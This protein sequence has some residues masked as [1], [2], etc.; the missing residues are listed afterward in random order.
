VAARRDRSATTASANPIPARLCS[1]IGTSIVMVEIAWE[2]ARP[3]CAP[4]VRVAGR[5]SVW[6]ILARA[7]HVPR[8]TTVIPR[9]WPRRQRVR[10]GRVWGSRVRAARCALKPGASARPAPVSWFVARAGK[11]AWFRLT[12]TRSALCSTPPMWSW[13]TSSQEAEVCSA[14]RSVVG[15]LGS[16]ARPELGCWRCLLWCWRADGDADAS[17]SGQKSGHV[18]VDE[19]PGRQGA[20]RAHTRR[21]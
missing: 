3:S 4:R 6:T 16:E 14:A 7:W 17:A 20:T 11:I 18:S 9:R 8:I 15:A 2:V 19:A 12:D 10:N 21:M 13:P 5:V 1:A